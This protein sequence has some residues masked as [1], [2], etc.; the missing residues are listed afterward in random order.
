MKKQKDSLKKFLSGPFEIVATKKGMK[1]KCDADCRRANHTY[2][3]K[4]PAGVDMYETA[5]GGFLIKETSD[6]GCVVKETA[7]SYPFSDEPTHLQDNEPL[8]S[9]YCFQ[10]NSHDKLHVMLENPPQTF[11]EHPDDAVLSTRQVALAKGCTPRTVVRH[12]TY[13]WLKPCRQIGKDFFF[14]KKDILA[15]I[16]NTPVKSGR[17]RKKE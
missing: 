10:K 11:E 14:M 5:D 2:R 17:P 3:H 4:F 8:L 12:V 7:E 13:G 16:K 6:G 9:S 1:H 15:W